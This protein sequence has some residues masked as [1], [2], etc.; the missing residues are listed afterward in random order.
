MYVVIINNEIHRTL[1]D[2]KLKNISQGMF[3]GLF[4]LEQL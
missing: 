3:E 4:L 1:T 2:N